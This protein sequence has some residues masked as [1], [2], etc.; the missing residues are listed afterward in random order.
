MPALTLT[1]RPAATEARQ[2]VHLRPT[3]PPE[4]RPDFQR[5]LECNNREVRT[6][7]NCPRGQSCDSLCDVCIEET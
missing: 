1:A 6:A 2:H 3:S 4:H 5:P 7:F